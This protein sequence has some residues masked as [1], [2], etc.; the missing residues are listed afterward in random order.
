[1]GGGDDDGSGGGGGGG[2]SLLAPRSFLKKSGSTKL[3][4]SGGV[5][6]FVFRYAAK[7][8]F[9]VDIAAIS[10]SSTS[11]SSSSGGGSNSSSDKTMCPGEEQLPK[12]HE[13]ELEWVVGRN[14]DVHEVALKDPVTGED[15]LR[16]ATAYGFRNIQAVVTKVKRRTATTAGST[17]TSGGVKK[18]GGGGGGGGALTAA[19]AAAQHR[20]PYSSASASL[21]SSSTASVVSPAPAKKSKGGAAFYDFVE[22]M[23]CPSGCLNGGAQVEY[24]LVVDELPKPLNK[25]KK[26]TFFVIY[27]CRVKC[28]A[29]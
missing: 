25:R 6:E 28:S 9:G 14:E 18:R 22:I 26:F 7:E 3:N 17:T 15:R 1:L 29:S 13:H 10:S 2:L 20:P 12:Q 5:G 11:T 23:A 27:V 16:F 4:G 21:S 8:L 24:E 19:A